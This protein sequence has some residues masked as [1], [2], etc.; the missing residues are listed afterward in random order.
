MMDTLTITVLIACHNRREKTL[1]CLRSLQKQDFSSKVNLQI[2]LVDD[3]SV[4]GTSFAVQQEFTEVRILKADGNLFWAGAMRFAWESVKA[5][6]TDYYLLLNDDTLLY[7]GALNE[8]LYCSYIYEEKTGSSAVVIGSIQDPE[9]KKVSY[10]GYQV[11]S[12]YQEKE[13]RVLSIDGEPQLCGYGNANA[14]LV[15]RY[16]TDTLGFF[17]PYFTHKLA[18]FDFTLVISKSGIPLVS[19]R[20]FIGSCVNDHG[21]NWLGPNYSLKQRLQYLYSNKHLAYYEYLYFI[22][23]HY[24][25]YLAIAFLKLWVKTLFPRIWSMLKR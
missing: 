24:R 5:E 4:D 13:K 20:I 21:A 2:V 15:P 17:D 10:G 9:S 16:V 22:R 23:K 8:M 1:S 7:R 14:L 19:T 6:S 3:G 12:R 18:D 25:E 11:R